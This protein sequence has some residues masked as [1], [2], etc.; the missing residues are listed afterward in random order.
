MSTAYALFMKEKHDQ[1]P[2]EHEGD[3]GGWWVYSPIT[4]LKK[5]LMLTTQILKTLITSL[6]LSKHGLAN[7]EMKVK[8]CIE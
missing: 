6:K 3:S 2:G 8:L 1:E 5:A 7:R 4:M